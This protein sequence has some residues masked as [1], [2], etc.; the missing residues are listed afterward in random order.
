MSRSPHDSLCATSRSAA[1]SSCRRPGKTVCRVDRA[2]G[3]HLAGSRQSHTA[4]L[5]H[6]C[7][8]SCPSTR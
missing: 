6:G 4:P 8:S 3:T 1:R 7:M 5:A 2:T